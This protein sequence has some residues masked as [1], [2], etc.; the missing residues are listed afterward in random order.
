MY[1]GCPPKTYLRNTHPIHELCHRSSI[2]P[3]KF[4][5]RNL[6]IQ[7]MKSFLYYH[8]QRPVRRM[9]VCWVWQ[10]L[11]M[12]TA[13]TLNCIGWVALAGDHCACHGGCAA[14]GC[15]DCWVLAGAEWDREALGV[16]KWLICVHITN[17][18]IYCRF[19]RRL[20]W[21]DVLSCFYW[22]RLWRGSFLQVFKVLVYIGWWDGL[23]LLSCSLTESSVFRL[24]VL[25]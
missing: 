7:F 22:W 13:Y 10:G 20:L 5:L 19:L 25:L 9:R 4:P 8:I 16:G 1:S 21:Q 18:L 24:W 17:E 23:Y 2:H 11:R 3:V 6:N 15:C 14:Q 12:C